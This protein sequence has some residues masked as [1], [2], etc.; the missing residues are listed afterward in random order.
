MP[1]DT[2]RFTDRARDYA[3][4]RPTY[5]PEVMTL[6]AEEMEIGRAHV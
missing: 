6:M 4:A 1:D 2:A 5:P 3:L